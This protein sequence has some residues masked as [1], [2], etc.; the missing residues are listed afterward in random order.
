MSLE[1]EKRSAVRFQDEVF[2]E[3]RIEAIDELLSP[4]YVE[5]AAMPPGVTP[6]RNGVKQQM[7][8]Y[9]R[10]FPDG[11]VTV[12]DTIAEGDMVV[13]RWSGVGTHQG[14]LFGT[15]P[16]GRRVTVTGIDINRMKDGKIVEHWGEI[17]LAGMLQQVG[18]MPMP[19]AAGAT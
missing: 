11:H 10:A 15:P 16:T 12:E 1:D 2:N 17:D 7:E 8:L 4:D 14:E 9:R 5:H 18:A 19:A 13:V 6:D 3:G